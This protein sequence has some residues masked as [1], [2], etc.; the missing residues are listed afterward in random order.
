MTGLTFDDLVTTAG[1]GIGCKEN[2]C[3]GSVHHLLYHDCQA[4]TASIDV[5]ALAIADSAVSPQRSPAAADCI[6]YGID[7]YNIQV[8]LLLTGEARER[9][10]F[11]CSGGAHSHRKRC[12]ICFP[13]GFYDVGGNSD[14]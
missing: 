12:R 6:E 1:E 8:G 10:V 7:P 14:C 2:A 5:V 13:N 9:K 4:H 3:D 11:C